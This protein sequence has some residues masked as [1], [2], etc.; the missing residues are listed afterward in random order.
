MI[1]TLHPEEVHRR[2]SD[3]DGRKILV[4]A[5]RADL[6]RKLMQQLLERLESD[7]IQIP[8]YI[9]SEDSEELKKRFNVIIMPSLILLE[10]NREIGRIA[11]PFDRER[12][13][14]FTQ[15]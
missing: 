13:K 7:A 14:R 3:G 10:G 6:R 5:G 4:F 1:T 8:I 11:G 2:V 15:S 12:F 9:L